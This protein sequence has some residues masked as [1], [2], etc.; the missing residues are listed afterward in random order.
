MVDYSHIAGERLFSPLMNE[1]WLIAA[2][3]P[4]AIVRLVAGA[5]TIAIDPLVSIPAAVFPAIPVVA[6][7]VAPPRRR[8]ETLSQ[9]NIFAGHVGSVLEA[10]VVSRVAEAPIVGVATVTPPA[11]A[12]VPVVVAITTAMPDAFITRAESHAIAFLISALESAG[13]AHPVLISA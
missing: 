3:I 6:V 1:S 9:S 4:A 10:D 13:W 2:A 5:V 11:S 12:I 8:I 7:I